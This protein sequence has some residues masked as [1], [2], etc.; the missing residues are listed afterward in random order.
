[1]SLKYSHLK[2]LNTKKLTTNGL[3]QA[4]KYGGVKSGNGIST[5][6]IVFY[7]FPQD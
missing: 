1:M 7:G 5:L 2:Q 4:Q 3:G 6:P